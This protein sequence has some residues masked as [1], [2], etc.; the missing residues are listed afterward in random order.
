MEGVP[1]EPDLLCPIGVS[2]AGR[3]LPGAFNNNAQCFRLQRMREVMLAGMALA[4]V[5]AVLLLLFDDSRALGAESEGLL[6]VGPFCISVCPCSDP[7]SNSRRAHVL[8]PAA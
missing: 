6:T 3:H 4:L 5:P 8:R 7:D 2:R 1:A